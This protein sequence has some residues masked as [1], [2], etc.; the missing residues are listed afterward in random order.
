MMTYLCGDDGSGP[1]CGLEQA[2]A[3]AA[4]R[5]GKQAARENSLEEDRPPIR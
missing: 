1:S 5:E 3:A 4:R 2:A